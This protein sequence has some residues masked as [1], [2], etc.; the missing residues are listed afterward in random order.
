MIPPPTNQTNLAE[1]RNHL[2]DI[3]I[4]IANEQQIREALVAI[5]DD[6]YRGLTHV[7]KDVIRRMDNTGILDLEEARGVLRSHRNY[8]VYRAKQD[9]IADKAYNDRMHDFYGHM[10]IARLEKELLR[11]ER[12][13]EGYRRAGRNEFNGNGVRSSARAVS[14]EGARELGTRKLQLRAYL[15]K[16]R[17]EENSQ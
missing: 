3:E 15:E 12:E 17:S 14:N 2:T 4:E 1:K 13:I 5:R 10:S 6:F 11:M 8:W 9:E 7:E 16:R